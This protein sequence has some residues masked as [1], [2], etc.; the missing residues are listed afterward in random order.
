MVLPV[1][2]KLSQLRLLDRLS[3]DR[4]LSSIATKVSTTRPWAEFLLVLSNVV[5]GV[6]S[7]SLTDFLKSSYLLYLSRFKLFNGQLKRL[8]HLLN[9][10][11]EEL[12]SI[13]MLVY[14]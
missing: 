10:L 14:L 4:S 5:P 3:E 1:L 12:K 6:A 13:R 9:F 2:E 8:N 7:M 11:A